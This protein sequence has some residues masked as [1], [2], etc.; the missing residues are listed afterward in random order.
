MISHQ[1]IQSTDEGHLQK[2]LHFMTGLSK[3]PPL[4]MQQKIELD[5]DSY[6]HS[7][8]AETCSYV[9]RVPTSHETFETF[10]QRV[11]E[12]CENCHGFG[13]T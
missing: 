1:I 5:F 10:L 9:L 6:S 13:S 12:A 3:I 8:F 4:G 2:L 7:F 11:Y